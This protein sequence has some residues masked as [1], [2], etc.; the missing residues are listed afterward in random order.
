MFDRLT[1]MN[2]TQNDQKFDTLAVIDIGSNSIRMAIG[3]LFENGHIHV[4]E[5]LHRAVHLG[6]DAFLNARLGRATMTAAISILRDFKKV[7]NLYD[8]KHISVVAT[9]ALR[10]SANSDTFID[11]VLMAT[12]FEVNIIN[13]PEESR[14]TVL[15]VREDMHLIKGLA[16]KRTL[17]AEVGGGSTVLTV[18]ERGRITASQTIGLGS[19]RMLEIYSSGTEAWKETVNLIKNEVSNAISSLEE[20]I[21]LNTIDNFLAI[22]ADA[23][24][25]ASQVGSDV[26]GSSLKKILKKDFT[27]FVKKCQYLPPEELSKKFEL[28]F[29]DAE[30]LNP[31]IF[32]FDGIIKN[33]KSD[34]IYV[35]NKSMRDGLMQDIANH[36]SGQYDKLISDEIMQSASNIAKKYHVDLK[37]AKKVKKFAA[38]LFEQLKPVHGLGYRELLM[39]QA[40]AILHAVGRYVSTRAYHKHS[41]YLIANSEILGLKQDEIQVVAHVARYQRRSR[42]KQSHTDYLTLTQEKRIKVNKL[43]AILRIADALDTSKNQHIKDFESK[44]IDDD[45]I[46]KIDSAGDI[47]PQKHAVAEKSDMFEDVYSLRV[48]LQ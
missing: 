31:A 27:K 5:R 16:G 47:S 29:T 18:M 21:P 41:Y 15:A 26:K 39:L 4:L 40:A 12:D 43:A 11:R 36:I 45:L 23:R 22:G 30:T 6:Q 34:S 37:H 46:L 19:I 2:K 44:I 17:I 9:S 10:E 38:K 35:T 13:T 33:I 42:P 24:F 28:P 7:I 25:T 20:F 3:Q 14:L 8:V 48:Q 1:D 32:I